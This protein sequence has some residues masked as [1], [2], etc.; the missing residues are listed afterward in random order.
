MRTKGKLILM[1]LLTFI[2]TLILILKL[3]YPYHRLVAFSF[4]LLT[5]IIFIH[6]LTK[7]NKIDKLVKKNKNS[8]SF[9]KKYKVYFIDLFVL[10]IIG[11]IL[12]VLFP[13]DNF[14]YFNIEKDVLSQKVNEDIENLKIYQKGQEDIIRLFNENNNILNKDFNDLTVEDK[15]LLISLWSS[16]LDYSKELDSLSQ[17]YK[18]FYQINYL[19]EPELNSK[20]FLIAYVA[21]ISNYES[22]FELNK[23]IN[24]SIFIKTL[25]DEENLELGIAKDS[26]LDLS[27]HFINVNNAIRLNVGQGNVLFVGKFRKNISDNEIYLINLSKKKYSSINS[28]VNFSSNVIYETP[29]EYFEKNTF[30]TWFP[31]QKGIANGMGRLKLSLRDKYI[32]NS[33]LNKLKIN[34]EPGDIFLQRRE[35]QLTNVGIPGFWTHA[36]LYLGNKNEFE[37]YFEEIISAND[38]KILINKTNHQFYLDYNNNDLEVIEA[39]ADGVI[40]NSYYISANADYLGVLRTNITKKDKLKSIIKAISYYKKPYDYNFDFV[41]DNELVCSELVFKAYHIS[42]SKKGIPFK[43]E[44]TSGR[45]MLSPNNI[46]KQYDLNL[47][48]KYLQFVAFLNYNGKEIIFDNEDNFRKTWKGE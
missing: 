13:V 29:L 15:K 27:V 14:E 6:S 20:S 23:L 40:L 7:L 16:Y 3:F 4:Y 48:D 45:L 28:L 41:T 36:A 8:I 31:A 25:F 26:Y 32:S 46:V 12:F 19:K 44:T 2:C 47:K 22:F 37:K 30:E 33:T 18:H 42:D 1:L 17:S 10:I 39:L 21:F 9:V 35:W 24:E 11:Y 43:L 38:L 5:W 34:L